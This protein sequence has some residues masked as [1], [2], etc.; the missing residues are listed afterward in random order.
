M[1]V[2]NEKLPTSYSKKMWRLYRHWQVKAFPVTYPLSAMSQGWVELVVD[3]SN[4]SNYCFFFYGFCCNVYT[5]YDLISTHP[6]ISS[7]WLSTH[8]HTTLSHIHFI[9]IPH[10]QSDWNKNHKKVSVV[11]NVVKVINLCLIR[12]LRDFPL[13]LRWK[14]QWTR[15]SRSLSA[16]CNKFHVDSEILLEESFGLGQKSSSRVPVS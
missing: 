16:L 13:K 9:H 3:N 2:N 12:P 5:D 6:T 1:R 4:S 11:K 14:R 15:F 8:R 10:P 7:F